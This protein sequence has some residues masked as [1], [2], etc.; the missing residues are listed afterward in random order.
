MRYLKT[1]QIITGLLVINEYEL[2][3]TREEEV[4][5]E[6]IHGNHQSG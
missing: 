5:T 4:E 3:R 2:E 6:E 1:L